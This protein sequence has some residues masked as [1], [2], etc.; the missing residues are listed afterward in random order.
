MS[1]LYITHTPAEFQQVTPGQDPAILNQAG[2][3]EGGQTI[4]AEDFKV[5]DGSLPRD[6]VLKAIGINK[7]DFLRNYA[8]N[9]GAKRAEKVRLAIDDIYS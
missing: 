2:E 9:F 7:Q 8:E 3:S 1:E 4:K 6:L 5:D